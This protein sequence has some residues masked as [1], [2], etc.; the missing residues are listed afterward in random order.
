MTSSLPDLDFE[1]DLRDP[2]E[3]DGSCGGPGHHRRHDAPPD[4]WHDTPP[5]GAPDGD[6]GAALALPDAD[7]PDG[8]VLKIGGGTVALHLAAMCWQTARKT[9]TNP[10]GPWHASPESLAVHDAYRKSRAWVPCCEPC[11]NAAR[12]CTHHGKYSGPAGNCYHLTVGRLGVT[13]GYLLAWLFARPIR[14][15]GAAAFI[16]IAWLAFHLR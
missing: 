16:G 7:V 2:G 12:A 1:F 9:V 5:D 3:A 4:G 6:P 11:R 13:A 10:R 14:L 8:V 15:G